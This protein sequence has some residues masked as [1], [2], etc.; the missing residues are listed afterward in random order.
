MT[1]TNA[2]FAFILSIG[3][4]S[5]FAAPLFPNDPA[6]A[7]P[8]DAS[9]SV[10]LSQVMREDA[11][12]V[13]G[14]LSITANGNVQTFNVK[15]SPRG[16]SRQQRCK[17]FPLWIN[18]KKSEVKDTVFAGQ[19]KLK[20]VTHCSNSLSGKGYVP[21]EMLVYRLFNLFTETSFRVRAVNMTYD[22]G[23]RSSQHP[24]FFIEHKK[25]LAKRLGGQIADQSNPKISQLDPN[26][27][28]RV[29]L[30]QYMIGNTDFSLVQGPSR[31]EC[32]HNAVPLDVNN[33]IMS[34]PYDF[35]VTGFVNVPYA[36]PVPSL[37]IKKLTQRLY[38]GYCRHNPQLEAE[39]E[40]FK[41]QKEVVFATVN[42]FSDLEGLRT[43]RH[44]RFLEGFY[45]VIESERSTNSRIYRKCR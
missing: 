30:F 2:L 35:D 13:A 32:C 21:A 43:K 1:W 31:E 8:L 44:I 28:A 41:A 15:V 23:K 22:D 9:L 16:K 37:G 42:S 27:S 6:K 17:F 5:S 38:R 39:I 33:Q 14:Q 18:F 20:L 10:D 12:E 45:N 26:M 25:E 40:F 4:A 7:P 3:S 29:T 34:V 19:N 36:G 11:D 24:A